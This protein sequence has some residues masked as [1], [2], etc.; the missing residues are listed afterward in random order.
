MKDYLVLSNEGNVK[1]LDI[2]NNIPKS[3]IIE[4]A[5][6]VIC[7]TIKPVTQLNNIVTY[8]TCDSIYISQTNVGG[9]G[10]TNERLITV[11]KATGSLLKI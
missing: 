6:R 11:N 3:K 1:I 10:A 8:D 4:I 9:P 7:E 5:R 2:P